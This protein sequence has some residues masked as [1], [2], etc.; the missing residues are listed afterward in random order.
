M[1]LKRW[2]AAAAAAA[3]TGWAAP[4]AS[5]ETVFGV[6]DNN[7]LVT[8]DS[9]PQ[10]L[11]SE[12][13]ITGLNGA[14]ERIVAIDVR[15]ATLQLYG[16]SSA[17]RLY[18]ISPVNGAATA[19]GSGVP[20]LDGN[21]VGID[22]DPAADLLRV[23]TDAGETVRI[24][25]SG[26]DV[27]TTGA[28]D[29][30]ATIAG[31]AYTDNGP[32]S[33]TYPSAPTTELFAI[34]TAEDAL[35]R[36]DPKDDGIVLVK[37]G[38]LGVDAGG[39]VGF[40]VSTTSQNATGGPGND[41]AYA[42]LRPGSDN[43]PR[44]YTVDLGS[45]AATE[46]GQLPGR[47]RV[48]DIAVAPDVPT[49]AM[50]VDGLLG[51][52]LVTFRADRPG[53]VTTV[54]AISGLAPLGERLVGI[55]R[56]PSD[57][58]L[59]GVSDDSRLYRID[60]ASGEATAV[61]APFEPALEGGAFGTDFDPTGD[62]LRVVSDADQ[63]LRIHPGNGTAQD[64]K[65]LNYV[66]SQSPPNPQV[67]AFG[68]ARSRPFGL[69]SGTDRVVEEDPP[70]QGGLLQVGDLGIDIG[71]S[72]GYEIVRRFN[73]GF[74]AVVAGG[75]AS[76]QAI[77]PRDTGGRPGEGLAVRIGFFPQSL[78]GDPVGLAVLNEASPIP[79][80]EPTPTPTPT[81]PPGERVQPELAVKVKPGRDRR[82]P[83]RFTVKGR[84]KPPAGVDREDAC[85]GRVRITAKRKA[86]RF[87]RK[88]T[89]VGD[90]CRFRTKVKLKRAGRRGR[91][92]FA[93]RFAGNAALSPRTVA[94]T[95][96]YGPR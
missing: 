62:R 43:I 63:S 11:L 10:T 23:V 30:A 58:N 5:A 37:V 25:P 8:F 17:D 87:A 70:G 78:A 1:N 95:V 93:V 50:L 80:P 33:A 36:S 7:R 35:Y 54:G 27:T 60:P 28:T 55:D 66:N 49:F 42:V 76:L 96:R 44:L 31:L 21:D 34:G 77:I 20:G 46:V 89:R 61:A 84:V 16:F 53:V 41:T 18:R 67:T 6:T 75:R 24:D 14:N 72:N 13:E 69:D 64:L 71:S 91:A 29:P 12:R 59:Y 81:P 40:D 68:Y 73:H 57:G 86:K 9:Q 92:R 65:P 2:T 85:Q 32:P 39:P 79:E 19:V 56:R 74:A 52:T 3:L 26:G 48:R 22:F 47:N 45:G 90:T 38:D 15:P 88:F 83:F 51:Q 82:R 4:A 94:R